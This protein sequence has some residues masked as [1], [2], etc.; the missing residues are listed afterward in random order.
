MPPCKKHPKFEIKAG[1][2][3]RAGNF[4]AEGDWKAKDEKK[5]Q[6][7]YKIAAKDDLEKMALIMGEAQM[8][9]SLESSTGSPYLSVAVCPLCLSE[10]T[11][12]TVQQI[13]AFNKVMGQFNIAPRNEAGAPF[14][15]HMSGDGIGAKETE[16]LVLLPDGKSLLD[17]QEGYMTLSYINVLKNL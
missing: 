5:R 14:I 13:L 15:F 11:D 3:F 2:Y 17:Y 8:T 6:T 10:T 9:H 4:K 12:T 16:A 7:Y 1:V